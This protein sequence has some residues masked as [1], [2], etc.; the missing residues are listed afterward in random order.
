MPYLPLLAVKSAWNRRFTLS[1]ILIAVA[2]STMLL[3]GVD[4]ARTSARQSFSQT[5]S[6]TDLIV[7]A[8]T[9][10]IQLLLYSVFHL[11]DAT[12]NVD[13]KSFQAIASHPD[14]AWAIPISLGDS[15]RGFPVL[16]TNLDYFKFF[17]YGAKQSLRFSQGHPFKGIFEAV[18]GSTIAKKLHYRIGDRI[19]L[20]HGTSGVHLAQHADKPFTVVGILEETGTP[21]DRT[22]HISLKA[23][24][25]IHL[26]WSGG[27]PI[28]GVSIPE[29]YVTKFD[30]T[31]KTI[32][33]ALVG[34]KSR[35]AVFRVQ[36]YVNEFKAEPLMAALPGVALD[37][38]WDVMSVAEQS[39]LFTSAMVVAA[40]LA[41]L[42]AVLLAGL[43]ERRRELA[44][45]RSVGAGP[46]QILLLIIGESVFVT[47]VA[48][49]AGLLVLDILTWISSP[50]IQSRYGLTVSIQAVSMNELT[51]LGAILVAAA[52]AS[53]I[54]ALK[55]YRQTLVDGLTPRI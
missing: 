15:H 6:A 41:G 50:W 9:G 2:L 45:L 18:I 43:G 28:P 46:W 34:L 19:I 10:A 38:L 5:V 52:I 44:I 7:G 16:G 33:A 48:C 49:I 39:L 42:V 54:P 55:A 8:R 21:V 51:L 17:R 53:T 23:M 4:R 22:V 35:I 25:A 12:N 31:P 30:L 37:Q 1:L 26:D 24:E 14:V 32:T 3:L 13:W 20:S 36:R 29:K 47:L 11:G 40:S 27:A